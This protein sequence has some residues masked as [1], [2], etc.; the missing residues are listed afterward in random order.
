M[1]H[2]RPSLSKSYTSKPQFDRA[3]GEIISVHDIG[4]TVAIDIISKDESSPHS[5]NDEH[6]YIFTE[7]NYSKQQAIEIIKDDC[8]PISDHA[9][10]NPGQIIKTALNSV[11]DPYIEDNLTN[12]GIRDLNYAMTRF[13]IEDK[14]E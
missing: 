5:T 2:Q 4:H 10:E 6:D 14:I 9:I 7:D 11:L 13:E 8:L 3:T 1:A 12:Q